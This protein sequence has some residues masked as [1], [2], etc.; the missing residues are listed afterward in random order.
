MDY[1]AVAAFDLTRTDGQSLLP[2][3]DVI[4]V[5]GSFKDVSPGGPNRELLGSWGVTV[6]PQTASTA[7]TIVFQQVPLLPVSS[8]HRFAGACDLLADGTQLLTDMSE[9]RLN[10]RLGRH[11]NQ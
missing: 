10:S 5:V 6:T 9:N 8:P 2:S 1:V 3:P 4:E 11:N 7:E